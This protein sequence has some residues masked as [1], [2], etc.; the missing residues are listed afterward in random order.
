M[1]LRTVVVLHHPRTTCLLA[2]EARQPSSFK[3]ETGK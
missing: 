3:W 2:F 1:D